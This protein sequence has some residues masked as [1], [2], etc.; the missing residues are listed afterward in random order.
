MASNLYGSRTQ[1]KGG[2][3]LM[4]WYFMRISGIVLLLMAVFHYALMHVF[5]DSQS[6]DYNWVSSRYAS[7]FWRTYDIILLILALIHGMNGVRY[8][9]DDYIHPKGLRVLALSVLYTITLTLLIYG[10]VGILTFVPQLQAF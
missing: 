3:E 10:M 9:V 8:V 2:V 4:A 1:P 5:R 6:I 7:P